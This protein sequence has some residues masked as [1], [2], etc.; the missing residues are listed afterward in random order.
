MEISVCMSGFCGTLRL[1][2]VDFLKILLFSGYAE[3]CID[4]L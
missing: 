3:P 4:I 2:P 1:T